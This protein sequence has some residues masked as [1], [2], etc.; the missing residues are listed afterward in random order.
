MVSEKNE[1]REKPNLKVL[2]VFAVNSVGF[3]QTQYLLPNRKHTYGVWI[4]KGR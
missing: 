2:I 3:L 4:R 1:A